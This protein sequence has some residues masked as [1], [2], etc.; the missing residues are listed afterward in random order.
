[1]L[2]REAMRSLRSC[3]APALPE[4][5]LV[6]LSVFIN[7]PAVGDRH[8]GP[9][10]QLHALIDARAPALVSYDVLVVQIEKHEVGIRA[11]LER[12]LARIEAEAPRRTLC[13]Q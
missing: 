12:A 1:M 13:N 3:H 6:D 11:G 2:G 7:D 9:T 4:C 10:L 5:P 8:D